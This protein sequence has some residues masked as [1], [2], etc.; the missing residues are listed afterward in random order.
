MSGTIR[1]KKDARYFVA[2]NE[3][4]N[5]KRLSW[6]ARGIMGYLLSKPDNWECRNRD[7]INNGPA[8]EYK[9]KRILSELKQYG[10]MKRTQYQ[11]KDGSFIW[12]TEIYETP[13]AEPEEQVTIGRLS[14]DGSPTNGLSTN[15]KP[16]DIIST[17]PQNTE[18]IN[19]DSNNVTSN[20]V[21]AAQKSTSKKQKSKAPI[22]ENPPSLSKQMF[23]SLRKLCGYSEDLFPRGKLNSNEKKLRGAG[24]SPGELE[25]FGR[26][27]YAND[28][29]GQKGQPPIPSQV[30]ECWGQYKNGNL[31]GASNGRQ[32]Q[33]S[34]AAL[35]KADRIQKREDPA[36]GRTYWFDT[37]L[38]IEVPE[39]V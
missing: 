8:G 2:S 23:S 12:I 26:W 22:K 13:I 10:Y 9:I 18:E 35:K 20:E 29:R 25:G 39:P 37:K 36:V 21:G 30:V 38:G 3:P 15:G 11:G 33:S 32:N 28:W 34:I 5:D 4:F 14:T 31:N 6:E 7:L 17:E 24:V 19:T 27:W 1:V 16:P